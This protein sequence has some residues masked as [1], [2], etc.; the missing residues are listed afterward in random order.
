MKEIKEHEIIKMLYWGLGVVLKTDHEI[1]V[2]ISIGYM[3]T[4]HLFSVLC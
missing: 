2:S 3:I 4:F 1:T